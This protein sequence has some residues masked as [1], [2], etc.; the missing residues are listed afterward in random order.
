MA[1]SV[2]EFN[3]QISAS[4]VLCATEDCKRELQDIGAPL[5]RKQ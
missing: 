2:L 4:A 1:L 5:N 3:E